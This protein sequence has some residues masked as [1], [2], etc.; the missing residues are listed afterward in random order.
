MLH[1]IH[2]TS[3]DIPQRE[4]LAFYAG[5]LYSKAM[6]NILKCTVANVWTTLDDWPDEAIAIADEALSP[7][8]PNAHHIYRVHEQ[9]HGPRYNNKK[10]PICK[11]GWDLKRHFI[12]SARNVPTGLLVDLGSAMA[13]EGYHLDLRD[14]RKKPSGSP[15]GHSITLREDQERVVGQFL[16]VNRGY[17]QAAT[18]FG[19]TIVDIVLAARLGVPTLMI[20]PTKALV[21][22]HAKKIEE[23]CEADLNVWSGPPPWRIGDINISTQAL[24]SAHSRGLNKHTSDIDFLVV[25]EAHHV[26][27]KTWYKTVMQID[28]YYR[29][30]QSALAFGDSDLSDMQLRAAIGPVFADVSGAEMTEDGRLEDTTVYFIHS[31]FWGGKLED[32]YRQGIV[33]NNVRNAYIREIN[34]AC[35]ELEV[36]CLTLVAWK[37]HLDLLVAAL[38]EKGVDR[39]DEVYGQGMTTKQM[40]E[41]LDRLQSG[42]TL[43][44]ISTT[45]FDEGIDVPDLPVLVMGG[46]HKR[47]R[48][49]IQRLGRVRRK[50]A[51]EKAAVFDFWDDADKQLEEHARERAQQYLDQG[52]VVEHIMVPIQKIGEVVQEFFARGAAT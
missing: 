12:T 49:T 8:V 33:E 52:C 34:Q 37:Q 39:L 30:G 10:C 15:W 17:L 51:W 4:R 9:Q 22:N 21:S 28:A 45:V 14:N 1:E 11:F 26:T 41:R 35:R 36:Q 7:T 25:D 29:L 44:C 32:P 20:V 16:E 31:H 27:A 42:E 46:A 18:A 24:L 5:I 13:L 6:M 19:K 3:R 40:N 38:N 23:L 43:C 50:G 47:D 2:N 48:R